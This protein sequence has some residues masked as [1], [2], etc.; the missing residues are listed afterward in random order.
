MNNDIPVN[1]CNIFIDTEMID[2]CHV[3]T[4]REKSFTIR[5]APRIFNIIYSKLIPNI[6]IVLVLT[7]VEIVDSSACGCILHLHRLLKAGGC[8]LAVVCKGNVRN[9]LMRLHFQRLMHLFP[10]TS[11]AVKAIRKSRAAASEIK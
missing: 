5:N 2:K 3:I 1:A 8:R 4:C 10:Q 7:S 11:D 9:T 6:D